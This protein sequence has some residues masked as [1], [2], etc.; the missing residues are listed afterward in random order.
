[1]AVP[2]PSTAITPAH[3]CLDHAPRSGGGGRIRTYG[4]V[5]RQ[6]YSLLPLAA[7]VPLPRKNE[8]RILISQ[9]Q[10]VNAVFVP[11]APFLA[12][13]G[14]PGLSPAAGQ[15]A[16]HRSPDGRGRFGAR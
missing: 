10:G 3:A 14:R 5:S 1:M 6:I 4:G 13:L 7:W 9:L 2:A 11:A 16:G 12:P 15:V 8:P